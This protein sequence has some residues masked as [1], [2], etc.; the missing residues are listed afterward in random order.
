MRRPHGSAISLIL[1]ALASDLSAQSDS[2]T[3]QRRAVPAATLAVADS[4][5]VRPPAS[6]ATPPVADSAAGHQPAATAA[7]PPPRRLS[8]NGLSRFELQRMLSE[9]DERRRRLRSSIEPA[10]S[11]LRLF[12]ADTERIVAIA[13]PAAIQQD[14]ANVSQLYLQY[15]QDPTNHEL[16]RQLT[17]AVETTSSDFGSVE[18]SLNAKITGPNGARPYLERSLYATVVPT[19][20]GAPLEYTQLWQK[21]HQSEDGRVPPPALVRADLVGF[22]AALSDSAF[23]SYKGSMR[24]AYA[25]RIGDIR[26]LTKIDR[27]ELTNVLQDAAQVSRDIGAREDSQ[28]KLDA[29]I[30]IIGVPALAVALIGLLLVPLLYKNID[31]QRAIFSSGLMLELMMVFLLTGSIILLGLDGRIPAELIGTLLGGLSGYMLGRSVNPL[32]VDRRG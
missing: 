24:L 20:E 10:D 17:A 16:L 23:R 22:F 21:L 26:E 7:T 14:S 12:A 19:S 15:R 5:A 1:I 32:I 4:A 29:R 18:K 30:I 13:R 6:A 9:L 28:S 3:A 27:D 8:T 11:A 31:L 25:A 2:A